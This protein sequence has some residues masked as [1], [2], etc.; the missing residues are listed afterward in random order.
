MAGHEDG[1]DL[2]AIV[3]EL[4]AELERCRALVK[5]QAEAIAHYRKMYDR[6]SELA[7][8]GV[9]EFDLSNE[10]LTWTDGVYDLFELPR[11]VPIDRAR[12]L[13]M[14]EEES[15][16]EMERLRAGI[17]RDGGSFTLDI[18][19]RTARGNDRW[20]RLTADAE[21]EQGRSVRIFGTKQN[22]TE[23][24][25]AQDKVRALQAELIQA[26]RRS[27]MGA[28]AA[29][30]AH[31][32]NQPL[33][34]ISNYIAGTRRALPPAGP[35]APVGEGLDAIDRCAARANNIIRSF[36]AMTVGST[37]RREPIDLNPLIHEA[38]AL[39]MA[40]TG[41][42]ARLRFELTEGLRLFADPVQIQQV[43]IN[44]IRN[45]AEA[46]QASSRR[47]ILVSTALLERSV[48]IRVEDTGHGIPAERLEYLF[49]SMV[50]SKPEGMGIGLSV[51][52]TIVEAHG[53]NISAA[54]RPAG[55]AA[56]CVELPLTPAMPAGLARTKAAGARTDR[57]AAG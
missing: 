20:L 5:E 4:S 16:R 13:A 27:A 53:G 15:R 51:S 35:T 28:M 34:A 25:S 26:S 30:L 33:A 56:F 38:G 22:V 41:G 2:P 10:T 55:G 57:R 48:R 31:E 46:V 12:I 54:N 6:S 50:S 39:A 9:W 49:D 37:V 36:R 23:E 17:I 43:L 47:E 18:R 42:D 7:Q 29:T 32:L 14:Y 1:R 8:I 52:R 24:K 3:A 19:I 40:R 45:A 11:G 21:R 44:L